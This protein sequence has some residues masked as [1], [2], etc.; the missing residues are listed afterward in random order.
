[1]SDLILAKVDRTRLWTLLPLAPLLLLPQFLRPLWDDNL[2][3]VELGLWALCIVGMLVV[4]G[5][6]FRPL[7]KSRQTGG[8]AL[9]I[10]GAAVHN[11][12]WKQA[13]PL[14]AIA[15]VRVSRSFGQPDTV[16]LVLH[17]GRIREVSSAALNASAP[18]IAGRI[19]ASIAPD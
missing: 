5:A 8:A 2:D 17:D 7:L 15:D 16:M 12:L 9:W 14:R 3:A 13:V 1:M 10:S 4:I 11:L 19:R 18:E 6:R